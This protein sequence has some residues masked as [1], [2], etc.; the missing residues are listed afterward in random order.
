MISFNSQTKNLLIQR[1]QLEDQ[2]ARKFIRS[3]LGLNSKLVQATKHTILSGPPGVGKT[4]STID[5]CNKGGVRYITISPGSSDIDIAVTLAYAVYN[6]PQNDDLCVILDD[7]DD[8]VFGDYARMNKWKIAMGDVNTATG[9][10]PHYDHA[11]SMNNTILALEK[12][13]RS[14]MSQAI[15]SFQSPGRLGIQIPTDRVRFIILCNKD[16]EDPKTFSRQKGM[17][18]AVEAIMDRFR[19]KRMKL[20]WET[21]WGWLAY[22]L[23]GTQPFDNYPLT[24]NQKKELLDW[25]YSNWPALRGTSYR[26]VR[27]LA[28]SMINNPTNYEDEWQEELKGK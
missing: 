16:L 9:S 24:D 5:E 19:Y 20:D 21:Q 25:M 14:D 26:T 27:K 22:V 28:E 15:K 2:K 3:A 1:G 4:H 17:T 6:L 23:N 7:A 13:G 10:I 8:V 18:S 11:V 12:A